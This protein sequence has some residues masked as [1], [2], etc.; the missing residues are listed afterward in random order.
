MKNLIVLI[1]GLAAFGAFGQTGTYQE[2]IENCDHRKQKLKESGAT[3]IALAMGV[4]PDCLEGYSIPEFEASTIAGDKIDRSYF[5]G[6]VTIINFWFIACPPCIAEIPGLAA[7]AEK[8]AGED[9]RFLAI[10]RD[11]NSDVENFLGDNFWPFDHIVNAGS[12][13][14][15][16]FHVV[17]GFP[18]TLVV[19]KNLTIVKAFSGGKP[20]E[21]AVEEI[22]Q[23]LI[24]IIDSELKK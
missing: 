4:R 16:P 14:E 8:Y 3:G 6:A 1:L 22:Q 17:W 5:E 11:G 18:M 24:P 2:G 20:D 12:L 19:D 21:S 23:K 13:M 7:L 9:V 10:G 15:D